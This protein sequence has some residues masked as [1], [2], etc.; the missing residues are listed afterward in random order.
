MQE[1]LLS[2]DGAL[3]IEDEIDQDDDGV[4]I[5]GFNLVTT[6]NDFNITTIINFMDKGVFIIPNFQRNFVWDIKKSSKLI[7]SLIMGLPIPQIFLYERERNEFYVID[8]QQRLLT[9]YFFYKGRFPRNDEARNI[10]K[11]TSN[12]S[13]DEFIP[14]HIIQDEKLFQNFSLKLNTRK[15][16]EN[17]K[18]H[19]KNFR[20]LDRSLKTDLEL[21]TIRNMVIKPKYPEEDSEH[22]AMFEIFNRLNS[23]GMN[24]SNQEIRMSLYSSDFMS[25]LSVM[26]QNKT[27]RKLIG[28]QHPDL[29]LKDSEL[30]LRLF[31]MLM[32]GSSLC[33]N[34]DIMYS[35]SL[36]GF[37]NSFA[38]YS[39]TITTNKLNE[40]IS[41]WDVVMDS[42][43]DI[44]PYELSNSKDV[45][46]TTSKPSIPVVEAL[47]SAIGNEFLKSKKIQPKID[48]SFIQSL[49]N[50]T[51]FLEYCIG[52][53]TSRSNMEGR[54]LTASDFYKQY[55][56]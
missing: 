31:S 46:N 25:N 14:E 56:K 23:G 6:P 7:E 3:Q 32:S 19:G 18:L 16:P 45:S 55:Y 12:S 53:T 21:S 44:K 11:N 43:S 9:L 28:K 42:L 26:N 50:K 49:K 38:N 5:V 36:V 13:F 24:L 30:V 29:R 39:R 22:L 33:I 48:S 10:I 35:N 15:E 51:D 8:G 2:N 40:L 34:G 27:W 52:K 41:T 54:L 4:D 37:L 20:T 1:R 47:F 17:N